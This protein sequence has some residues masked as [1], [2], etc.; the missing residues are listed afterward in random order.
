[1]IERVFL[2]IDDVCNR[3]TMNALWH[4]GCRVDP[5]HYAD[6]PRPGDYDIMRCANQ[7]FGYR[8]FKNKQKFWDLLPRV[9]WATIPPSDEM[10]MLLEFCEALVGKSNICLLSVP[11]IDP[12]CLAG[13]L[14]WI[15]TFMPKW[16]HRQYYIGPRKHF[17]AHPR[18]LLIDD[19]DHNVDSFRALGG[20]AI[21]V[22][23]P[24]NSLHPVTDTDAHLTLMCDSLLHDKQHA[25]QITSAA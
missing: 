22:P 4:V 13:K 8:R 10:G 1:M 11:T 15:H 25:R 14:D 9:F 5:A 18:A 21:L 17:C 3:F 24:W 19:S 20:Q 23:R 6:Y 16:L 7:L 12:N 2:D